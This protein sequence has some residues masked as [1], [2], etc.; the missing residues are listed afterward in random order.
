MTTAHDELER[1]LGGPLTPGLAALS[2]QDLDTL[3]TAIADAGRSQKAALADA[4]DDGLNI[5]PR[6]LRGAV[7]KALF[8]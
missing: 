4:I 7:R 2:D 8:G 5:V 3:A 1:L 6:V